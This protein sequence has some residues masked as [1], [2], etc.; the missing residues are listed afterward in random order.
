M[1]EKTDIQS[2]ILTNTRR[3]IHEQNII[4]RKKGIE[5]VPL[6]IAK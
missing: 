4:L 6:F 2:Y 1:L 5:K 3:I